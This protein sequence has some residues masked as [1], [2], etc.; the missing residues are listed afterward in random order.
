MRLD[1]S[2][3]SFRDISGNSSN[4]I[5]CRNEGRAS[6]QIIKVMRRLLVGENVESSINRHLF[7]NTNFRASPRFRGSAIYR[8]HRAECYCIANLFDFQANE[9]SAWE[10]CQNWL[11][12][13]I[14]DCIKAP[15][16]ISE[17][18]IIQRFERTHLFIEK[19]GRML[20][21]LHMALSSGPSPFIGEPIEVGDARA[22][23]ETWNM[24]LERVLAVASHAHANTGADIVI[25]G[26]GCVEAIFDEAAE[27]F[28]DLPLKIR[29]HGD[30]HLGQVLVDGDSCFI[31]DYEGEPLKSLNER[32]VLYPPFKDLAGM[33][34]SFSY[35]AFAA[36]FDAKKRY[37]DILDC[38]ILDVCKTWEKLACSSFYEGWHRRLKECSASFLPPDGSKTLDIV[39]RAFMLDKVLYELEYEINNRPS[40]LA[41]PING[42]KEILETRI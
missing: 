28:S 16:L 34:R 22:F 3:V 8:T 2:D 11:A 10:W 14:G 38:K 13:F 25:A 39:L 15:S 1:N 30:F 21:N 20:A 32:T 6:Q 41:I 40:W 33:L 26:L 42:V 17:S 27:C 7:T 9:G 35:A 4:T 12:S 31:I 5:L 24:Q 37:E 19:M 23:R 29:Q 36:F 18:A